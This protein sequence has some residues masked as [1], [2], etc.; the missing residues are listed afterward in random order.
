MPIKELAID[1]NS[2]HFV[3]QSVFFDVTLQA[4]NTDVDRFGLLATT[5][6]NA[7]TTMTMPNG[8]DKSLSVHIS[9]FLSPYI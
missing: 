8:G 7:K 1:A 3:W 2:W 5:V 4:N 9:Q 6:K